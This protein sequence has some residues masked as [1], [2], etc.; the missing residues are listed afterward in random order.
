MIFSITTSLT[1]YGGAQKV[2]IDVHNGIRSSF[3]CKVLGIHKYKNLHPKYNIAEHEYMQLK[4]PWQLKNKVILVHAR[5]ILP[6]IVLANRLLFLRAK[7]VYVAHNVYSTYGKVTLMPDTVVSISNKVTDNLHSYFKIGPTKKV[8]LVY[9]GIPDQL[10]SRTRAY[11]PKEIK[12]LYPARVNA[13]KRQLELVRCLRTSLAKNIH[14]YF[15][16]TGED[17]NQLREITNPLPNF[18][19]LGFVEDMNELIPDFD[20]LMLYSKQEGLPLSLLEGIMHGKPLLVN[21]VGGNLEIGVPGF[22]G[23]KLEDEWLALAGQLNRLDAVT[24]EL[25]HN[26]ATNSR[27]LYLEKFT[28]KTMV[29][30]YIEIINEVNKPI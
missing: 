7:I 20:Y 16:G 21:D 22:N 4:N 17:F 14:I 25:Y 30:K 6:F 10:K 11:N 15:A 27:K 9:N 5:N 23:Y 26:M 18:H 13:V 3:S 2:L 1:R 28:Y 29:E 19:A 8:S 24:P 12:I